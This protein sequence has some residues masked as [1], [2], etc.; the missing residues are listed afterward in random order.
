MIGKP[1]IDL[2]SAD[3]SEFIVGQNSAAIYQSTAF[4][5]YPKKNV[6]CKRNISTRIGNTLQVYLNSA[7][8]VGA[9]GIINK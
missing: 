1:N 2:C 6:T 7:I 5:F 8:M 4:P 9:V 3:E